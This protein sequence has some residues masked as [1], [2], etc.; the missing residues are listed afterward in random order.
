MISTKQSFYD[1]L[2]AE[3]ED[4]LKVARMLFETCKRQGRSCACI[5]NPPFDPSLYREREVWTERGRGEQI[6]IKA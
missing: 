6:C 4:V 1:M 3:N 5:F 2:Q